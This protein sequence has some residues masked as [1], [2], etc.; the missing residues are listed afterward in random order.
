METFVGVMFFVFGALALL[1]IWAF[2]A[3]DAVWPGV[4][5]VAGV[6]ICGITLS[7]FQSSALHSNCHKAGG[8][9]VHVKGSDGG[10]ICVVN[11][12]V[13]NV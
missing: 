7:G 4:A 12:K 2:M 5:G 10:N 6:L 11:G 3:K 13:V 9:V 1:G 8:S